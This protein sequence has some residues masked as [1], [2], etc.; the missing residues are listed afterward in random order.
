MKDRYTSALAGLLSCG[1]QTCENQVIS[2]ISV[3]MKWGEKGLSPE[4]QQPSE[5]FGNEFQSINSS[6]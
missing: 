6:F 1:T 5:I 4:P 2:L 3:F